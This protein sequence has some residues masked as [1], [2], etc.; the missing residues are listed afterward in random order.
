MHGFEMR[1]VTKEVKSG[2]EAI[3]RRNLM[4]G[5]PIASDRRAFKRID[6]RGCGVQEPIQSEF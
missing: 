6:L 3:L 4:I 1:R 5:K 2:I